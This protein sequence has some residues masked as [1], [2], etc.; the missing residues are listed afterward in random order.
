MFFV[1]GQDCLMKQGLTSQVADQKLEAATKA[2][3]DISYD[4][5]LAMNFIKEQVS[6]ACC[7]RAL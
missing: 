4:I 1:A 3:S 6:S 7:F 5:A 2:T